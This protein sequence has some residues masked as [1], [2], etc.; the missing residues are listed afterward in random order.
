MA[1]NYIPNVDIYNAKLIF[2]NFRGLAKQF[3]PAGKRN[4]CVLLDDATAEKLK[5]DHWR[6]KY[7][8]P[9]EEGDSPRPYLK[10]NVCYGTKAN[11]D[12]TIKEYGP[13]IW[14]ITGENKTLQNAETVGNIDVA[15][16]A[17]A[18]IR[19]RPFEYQGELSAYLNKAYITAKVDEFDMFYDEGDPSDLDIPEAVPF[20]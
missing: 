12:G 8:Q 13:D 15:D 3:N 5:A 11:P 17:D 18:R 1:R 6:I 9:R 2:K 10:V 16:I 4:F 20:D 19:I 7:L 14:L